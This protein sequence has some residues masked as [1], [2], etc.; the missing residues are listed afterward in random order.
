M[1]NEDLKAKLKQLG[2]Q[3]KAEAKQQKEAKLVQ[4]KRQ[5]EDGQMDF[6][7]AVGKVAPIK[8]DGRV[9]RPIECAPIKRRQQEHEGGFAAGFFVGD[10]LGDE[11]PKMFCKNGRGEDD[12]RRLKAGYWPRMARLDLHGVRA[13]EAQLR[14]NEFVAYVQTIGVCCEIVHGSGLGSQ[15]FRPV[16][17]QVVRR[18][19]MAHPEVLAYAEPH[20]QND[21]AV[22]V[23]LKKIRA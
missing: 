5:I 9:S 3:A 17:K 20:P 18:W 16:L 11:P 22:W 6:A 23:L 13:E 1:M 4:K 15:G 2:K 19:L 14:L 8:D 12:I 21:G 7:K 10:G